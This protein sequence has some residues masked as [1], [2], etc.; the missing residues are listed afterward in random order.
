MYPGIQ[1][2]IVAI[3]TP[4]G[5]S[6][7]AIIKISGTEAIPCVKSIFIP[8]TNIDLEVV[9]TYNAAKGH[10]HSPRE[11]VNIPV[12]LY[13]MKKPCSYTKEDVVEIHTIGSP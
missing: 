6:L 10:I 9:L 5:K 1:D 8:A 12:L 13:I 2:T 3:S 7:D 4:A 11:C